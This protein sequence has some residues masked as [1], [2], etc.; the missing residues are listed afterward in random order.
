MNTSLYTCVPRRLMPVIH[1]VASTLL[2]LQRLAR[3]DPQKPQGF[4]AMP[5]QRIWPGDRL[6][7]TCD[8]DSSGMVHEVAAGPTHEHE[9]CNM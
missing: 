2:G 4:Y 1:H 8:F 6:A 9:M 7:V 5:H 3:G